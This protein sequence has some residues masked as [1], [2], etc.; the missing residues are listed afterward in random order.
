M[1]SFSVTLWRIENS[2]E[3]IAD[4][5]SDRTVTTTELELQGYNLHF[6][7]LTE[8]FPYPKMSFNLEALGKLGTLWP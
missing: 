6:L 3:L 7:L 8:M 1:V 4:V 2:V 5:K